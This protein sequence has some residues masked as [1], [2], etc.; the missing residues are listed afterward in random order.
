MK[1]NKQ[2]QI[3]LVAIDPGSFSLKAMAAVSTS[4]PDGP[5][6][7]LGV[8]ESRKTDC[9]TQGRITNTS[10]TGYLLSETLKL[11][12][13]R[14]QQ[15]GSF[16]TAFA[17]IG[18]KSM[19]SVSIPAK[20][21]FKYRRPVISHSVIED[22]I[23]ECKSKFKQRNPNYSLIAIQPSYFQID[24][25]FFPG[26]ELP[27]GTR[28]EN[29][30]SLFTSFY[31][32][33]RMLDEAQS[34]F[35]RSRAELESVFPRPMALLEALAS[36]ED[37]QLGLAIIDFG[38]ETTTTTVY[39]RGE[40][41]KHKVVPLGGKHITSDISQMHISWQNA[42]ALKTRYGVA[43]EAYLKKNPT[44]D[45]KSSVEGEPNVRMPM[46][47]LTEIINS[48]LD[49]IL[50]EPLK[51]LQQYEKDISVVYIT[52]GASK[53]K[54]LVDYLGQLISIPVCYGSHD[55]WLD[56]NTPEEFFAPD[57]SALVGTLL[58]ARKYRKTHDAPEQ[59][60]KNDRLGSMVNKVVD[61][62]TDQQ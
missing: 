46:A 47:L 51:I 10:S 49:E 58:L 23:D 43:S 61:L 53:L 12:A 18:G 5:L 36:E 29:I 48:R 4:N 39:K 34:S 35:A 50:T 13:N 6:Q 31:G 30:H 19:G 20:R 15:I 1:N 59:K 8:E 3:P 55:V 2:I 32:D 44:F 9:I 28:G 17:C 21:S 33:N 25:V 41:L 11:L 62:F 14:T 27:I 24:D 37:E 56:E 26:P 57:Y 52:G 60:K 40:Y 22:M 42:E 38:A 16:P 54:N 45:I 7:L